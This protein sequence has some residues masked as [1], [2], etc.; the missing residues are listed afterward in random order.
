MHTLH[1]K[2]AARAVMTDMSQDDKGYVTKRRISQPVVLGFGQKDRKGREVKDL[3]WKVHEVARMM[4]PEGNA[5]ITYPETINEQS[6]KIEYNFPGTL[7]EEFVYEVAHFG[8]ALLNQ[9]WVLIEWPWGEADELRML[10]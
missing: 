10:W 7:E 1:W 8:G 5:R 2:G 3:V 9:E 6:V 4:D